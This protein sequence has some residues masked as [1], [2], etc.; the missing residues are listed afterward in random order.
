MKQSAR[1]MMRALSAVALL[2]WCAGAALAQNAP[3]PLLNASTPVDWWFVF[4][5]NAATGPG[6]VGKKTPSCIFG[7]KPGDY[8]N[9]DK[10]VQFGQQ[11]A[12]ASNL[13]PT[14]T[15]PS[16]PP[17]NT[18]LGDSV[19]DPVGATYGQIYKSTSFF[20]VVWNDQFDNSPMPDRDG[21]WGHS[22]GIVAWDKDGNGMV[23]Q[24]STPSWPASGSK[25]F[26]RKKDGN[27]LGCVDDNDVEVSQHFF[28]L[29]LNKDD[30]LQVLKA[31]A[32][33]SVATA[34]KPKLPNN[35]LVKNG[36]PPEVQEAVKKLGVLAK[37]A[38]ATIVTLSSGV[39]L[40]SKPSNLIVPPWQMVSALLK[41]GSANAGPA[42]K[43][44][45][46]WTNPEISPT[47]TAAKPGCWDDA[48]AT[49][50]PVAIAVTGTWNG[51]PISLTGGPH[52]TKNHA[53]I[54]VSEGGG[55]TLS[56]FGDMNQQGTLVP[57][58]PPKSKTHIAT[59][60][61]S[62]NGRGGTFYV[63][64]NPKLFESMTNLL[65]GQTAPVLPQ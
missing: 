45:T 35:Q 7:G 32:N 22:K 62:Q 2:V 9:Y 5:F 49:P 23:M 21:P 47:D 65:K 64:D 34:A 28:A 60:D 37:S 27:T 33:A 31:L 53:K 3:Q 11:F 48:L 52:T 46:W 56:I 16:P 17:G 41:P 15:A 19:D 39:R 63:L 51:K 24:V 58:V 54:G 61:S 42:L 10:T 8:A 4:K 12:V 6:C 57:V 43:A 20:Y 30:L 50:G 36:G 38:T 25:T 59:C 13:N 1:A 55:A 18:C 44:A 26:P 40:I 29:K 14:L